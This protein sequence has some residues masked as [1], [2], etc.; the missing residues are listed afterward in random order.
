MVS[1]REG[2]ADVL[3]SREVS[4]LSIWLAFVAMM[5]VDFTSTSTNNTT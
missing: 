5:R 4:V 2:V 1:D 3:L